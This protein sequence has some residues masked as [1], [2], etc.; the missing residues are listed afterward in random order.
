MGAGIFMIKND[1]EAEKELEANK[2]KGVELLT[3]AVKDR[4][5]CQIHGIINLRKVPGKFAF[6]F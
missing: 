2:T 5:G 3:Q 4:E 1:P 6:S